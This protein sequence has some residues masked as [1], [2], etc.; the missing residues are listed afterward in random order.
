FAGVIALGWGIYA[1]VARQNTDGF[2]LIG[3]GLVMF[4]L[5]T[6]FNKRTPEGNK[7]Y[8]RLEGFRQFVEKAERPVIERLLKD[9]PH[10]YDKTMPYA[11]AFGYLKQWNRMFD[12]LLTEP[13]S[14][15][16]GP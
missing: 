4:F 11:L 9:D 15:Y 2:A 3:T 12:G 7:T 13:P 1:L 10:Y 16:G 8:Q 5:A 14:W 6:R